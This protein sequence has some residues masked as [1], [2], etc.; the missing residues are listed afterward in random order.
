MFGSCRFAAT[1][2]LFA[3]VAFVPSAFAA[4]YVPD[5][6][7]VKF[8]P[9]T[10]Q[11][12][13]AVVLTRAGAMETM[14]RIRGVGAKVVRVDGN[15]KEIAARLE[16]SSAVDYAEV[17]KILS[18][19]ATP[20]DSEFADQWALDRIL[21]PQGWSL[22]GLSAFPHYGGVKVGI[23]DTGIDRS[24]P[25]FSGRVSNCAQSTTMFMV[26]TGI[27]DGCADVDG[28][29][30]MV[31][32][33]LGARANNGAG[34]AGVAF[35]SPLA[36]C[37]ALEDGLGRG[38]T[39]NVVN[40]LNWLRQKGAKVISMS[41]GGA[42]SDTLHTAVKNAWKNGYGSVLVAAAGNSGDYTKIYPASYEEVISVSATDVDDGHAGSNYNASVEL[43]APGVDIL[44]TTR[45][46]GYGTGS[47]T[48]AA[49][50]YVAGVAALMRQKYPG[51]QA[52][53]I[54]DGLNATADDLGAAGRDSYFGFGR[55][56]LCHAMDPAAC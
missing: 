47:G 10:P 15:E 50:P 35:N 42:S 18:A 40:C 53:H 27:R 11:L 54:R 30:T 8:K 3:T 21:A 24:H 5:R 1:V 41:F 20:N 56:N 9:G 28:H 55:V 26:G 13:Q 37:R 16:R 46:G 31:A 44:T 43:S 48:S 23:I 51:A 22:A 38:S 17:D 6:V 45:G 12:K 32:G 19:T 34:V 33:I 29:G 25:E 14:G 49:A 2:A 7:I 4:D 36:I 39:S 52:F